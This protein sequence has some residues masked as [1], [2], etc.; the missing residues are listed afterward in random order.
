MQLAKSKIVE[1]STR[2]GLD[3]DEYEEEY[4]SKLGDD[5]SDIEIRQS[6]NRYKSTNPENRNYGTLA[7]LPSDVRGMIFSGQFSKL[8]T[9]NK[10]LRNDTH[11]DKES[12]EQ[13]NRGIST[14]ELVKY[15]EEIEKERPDIEVNVFSL[16]NVGE[17][18]SK[19]D[20]A[21]YEYVYDDGTKDKYGSFRHHILSYGPD[22]CA[23]IRDGDDIPE[24]ESVNK[25]SLFS[26][27]K[28]SNY[29]FDFEMME[30]ILGKRGNCMST[31]QNYNTNKTIDIIRTIINELG[32]DANIKYED[33]INNNVKIEQLPTSI[34]GTKIDIDSMFRA[35]RENKLEEVYEYPFDSLDNTKEYRN[36]LMR[37][38]V[39]LVSLGV[40][41]QNDFFDDYRNYTSQTGQLNIF[42]IPKVPKND[43][44]KNIYSRLI[45][46]IGHLYVFA[47]VGLKKTLISR[48]EKMLG[49]DSVFSIDD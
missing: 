17:L 21:I 48:D 6:Y 34:L 4:I 10:T 44:T 11:I 7:V 24:G 18:L 37:I 35:Y 38:F 29:S 47:Y 20:T 33:L 28:G 42:N 32:K 14:T 25:Y 39:Y 49:F 45:T 26:V 9:I 15:V 23:R 13:C 5:A 19:R 36:I 16:V 30:Q 22:K 2:R 12:L 43:M 40:Y 46:S 3:F 8:S 31:Y 27:V 41:D 1:S